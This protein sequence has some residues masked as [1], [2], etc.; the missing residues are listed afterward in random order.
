MQHLFLLNHLICINS[1]IFIFFLNALSHCSDFILFAVFS[2]KVLNVSYYILSYEKFGVFLMKFKRSLFV[3]CIFICLFSVA[4]VCASDVNEN[5]VTSDDI[6]IEVSQ[7]DL[8]NNE[9][10]NL[11]LSIMLMMKN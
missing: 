11:D 9:L 8:K 10:E 4:S 1:S 6:Q 3:I 5:I 2:R 7:I